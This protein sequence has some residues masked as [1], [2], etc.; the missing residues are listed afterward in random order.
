MYISIYIYVYY[1]YI[2]KGNHLQKC[3]HRGYVSSQEV[4]IVHTN[5]VFVNWFRV[6]W[7]FSLFVHDFFL[8]CRRLIV[9]SFRNSVFCSCIRSFVPSVSQSVGQLVSRSFIQSFLPWFCTFAADQQYHLDRHWFNNISLI[10]ASKRNRLSVSLSVNLL[11]NLF[12]YKAIS[13][14]LS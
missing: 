7:F 3:L 14:C 10:I 9:C 6:C 1:M 8:L 5:N 11:N 4:Y 2:G 12:F 13:T